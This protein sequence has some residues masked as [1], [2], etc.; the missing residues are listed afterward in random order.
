MGN[1]TWGYTDCG[2]EPLLRIQALNSPAMT[3]QVPH[4]GRHELTTHQLLDTFAARSGLWQQ[5]ALEE[6]EQPTG[7]LHF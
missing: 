3:L 7:M 2:M 1:P 4:G 5:N 6:K